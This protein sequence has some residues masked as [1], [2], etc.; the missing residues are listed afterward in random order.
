MRALRFRE[1]EY[2]F[3]FVIAWGF[4]Y[5][6]VRVWRINS[7]VGWRN[8]CPFLN[9]EYSPYNTLTRTVIVNWG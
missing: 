2:P 4:I 9:V 1:G 5:V 6:F 3:N 8:R 7:R